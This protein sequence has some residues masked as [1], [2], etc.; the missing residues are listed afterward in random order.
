M[1]GWMIVIGNPG[2]DKRKPS[3]IRHHERKWS[4]TKNG[5]KQMISC[6]NYHTDADYLDDCFLQIHLLKL[7]HC[8]MA[9]SKRHERLVYM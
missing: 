3:Y 9:W 6:R 1:T 2:N 5:K 7:N 4:H 8:C